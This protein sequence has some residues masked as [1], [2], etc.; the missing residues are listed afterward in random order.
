MGCCISKDDIEE[1]RIYFENDSLNEKIDKSIG[2]LFTQFLQ[3]FT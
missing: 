3:Y 1:E 2:H